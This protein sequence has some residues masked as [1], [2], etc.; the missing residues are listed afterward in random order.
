MDKCVNYK[1]SSQKT[2]NYHHIHTAILYNTLYIKDII[3]IY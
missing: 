2:S 3:Y 1:Y